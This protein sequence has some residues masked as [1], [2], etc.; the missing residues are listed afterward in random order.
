MHLYAQAHIHVYTYIH[1]KYMHGCIITGTHTNKQ[2]PHTR[3]TYVEDYSRRY[4]HMYINTHTY[5]K[6]LFIHAHTFAHIYSPHIHANIHTLILMYAHIFNNTHTF[7]HTYTH[8]HTFC[9]AY[10]DLDV[11]VNIQART[12]THNNKCKILSINASTHMFAHTYMYT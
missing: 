9:H 6:H 4:T 3:Q 7:N 2:A 1:I 12:C 5:L 8:V 11:H 10:I